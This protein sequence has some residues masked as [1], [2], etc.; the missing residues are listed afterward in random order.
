M[1]SESTA[2][3]LGYTAMPI[4]YTLFQ[5]LF[6]YISYNLDMARLLIVDDEEKIREMIGK[7]ASFEGYDVTL[8]KDGK[9]ALEYFQNN[10]YDVVILDVMMPVMDGYETLKRMRAIKDVHC[11]FLTALGEENDRIY[12]F[13]VGGE[14]YVTKPFSLKELMMRIKVILKRDNKDGKHIVV[15]GLVIDEGAHSVSVDGKNIDLANKEYELLLFLVKNQGKAITRENIIS[16]IWGYKYDGDD[17]TL[18]THM[19]LLR[20]DIGEYGKYITTIRGVG[21]RFEKVVS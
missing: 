19:K 5:F 6:T 12:G 7:Y 1:D 15:D 11:I 14:D 10:D 4:N 20:R 9:E 18:D 8:A 17:R 2:L 16:T 3:P 21:Y 13:D